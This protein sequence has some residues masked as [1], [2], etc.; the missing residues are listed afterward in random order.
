M[1]SIIGLL[2]LDLYCGDGCWFMLVM[3]VSCTSIIAVGILR[4]DYSSIAGIKSNLS[5]VGSFAAIT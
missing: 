5:S 1:P 3:I 4:G 2:S